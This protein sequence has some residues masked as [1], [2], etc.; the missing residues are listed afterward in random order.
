MDS[1]AAV[2]L[3][4]LQAYKLMPD[5]LKTAI[6]LPGELET[7]TTADGSPMHIIGHATITL[8][9]KNLRVT[10]HFIIVESLMTDIILGIDF[11]REY[12]ISYDWDEE[13]RCYIRHNGQF[14]CYT[15]DMESGINRVSIAKTIC[16]PPRHNG[17]VSVSIRGHDIKIPTTCF[18]GSQYTDPE[19]KLIDGVHD[20]SCNVT[21]Q[22][23]VIN[24]SNQ[25]VNFPKGMKIGHLEPPIDELTQIP[26]NS[27]TTQ[28]MLPETVKPDSFTPPKYQLDSTIQQQLDN[29]LR[30][31]KDQFAKDEA[32]I[33]TTLLT[34]MSI[35]TG[36]SDPVS[37]KPYPVAMKHY[38]WVK[39]EIDKLL[40][41][42][43]IRNSHSSWL[44]PIIVVPKGDGGKRLIIDYRA[45]NKVMRKFIWPM[46]KVEDI[47]SQLNGAKYFST[48][49]LRAG[50]HHIGLTTDSIPKTAFKSP[51]GKY[52]YVKVP[53]GLAQA[54]AYFQELMTGVLKDLPFA[55]AYLDDIII[56]SST[57]EEH[58]Q[59]IKTVFEK[60]CH[61]KLS[62]K[63]SKCHF[64]SKEIQYLGHILGM[65]GIRPVPAKTEAI[66]AMHLPV[67]PKQVH[68]FLGLVGYYRKFIKNFAEIA[69]PLTVLTRMDVKFKWKE[70]HC[71][72]FMKLKDTIIQAPIL[73]YL[74]TTK[75]YIVYTDASDDA[76]G[77]QLS[78][79]HEEAEF[80]VVFLS[81]TFTD[82]QQRWSTPEQEAYSIYF[83]VKKWNYYLQGADIII[84]ND[85]KP[86]AWFLNGKNKNTKIN[87]WELELP[88]YNIKFEWISGAKN[89]A[90]DCLS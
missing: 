41:A 17:A 2:S 15:E 3:I 87:R 35:D 36:D 9:L 25:H 24:N 48:L 42:G 51:F 16:I 90:T 45:L 39:E 88:S 60:L 12:Q 52:E 38:N 8:H 18:I 28:Q 20:I 11:H 44:A 83:T 21:L 77:A 73:R 40:E 6:T 32:T 7:L 29:L 86:L 55:M 54:P 67:N 34:Q 89:K 78:Q 58:L 66:K 62:I 30:T 64:F 23:L 37:Q 65:E 71:F 82:T 72:T 14:L 79:M 22:V 27:A 75:P 61:A 81:H 5:T 4:H 47:F 84:R 10:H 31:F 69:K 59:H 70:T 1:G 85:H 26:I 68:A 57:P 56:Y 33:G 74:D 46:P 13:K 76:C 53:F 49:D 50:Y 63:L 19:V 80:P 43:V